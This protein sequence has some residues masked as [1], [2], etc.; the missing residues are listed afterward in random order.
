MHRNGHCA[1]AVFV[2][3]CLFILGFGSAPAYAGNQPDRQVAITIDD[4]PAGNAQFMTAAEITD[5]T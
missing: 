5:M 3:V 1:V 2:S 4:L